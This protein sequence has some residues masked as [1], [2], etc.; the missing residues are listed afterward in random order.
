MVL[1]SSFLINHN[2]FPPRL[3]EEVLYKQEKIH[4]ALGFVQN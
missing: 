4:H 1:T 2:L 3:C